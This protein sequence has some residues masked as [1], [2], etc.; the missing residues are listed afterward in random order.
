MNLPE[1]RA[2]GPPRAA[3]WIWPL[4]MLTASLWL[5]FAALSLA[6]FESSTGKWIVTGL[7]F[8]NAALLFFVGW[9][10]RAGKHGFYYLALA[11]LG[12]NL[13]L[14]V[15]DQFGLFD[16][17]YLVVAGVLFGLLIATRRYYV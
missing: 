16:L 6:R 5:F 1:S 4:F 17:I 12:I 10:V 9:G 3:A 8:A 13:L 11:V 15:T 14:T 7:M 2:S